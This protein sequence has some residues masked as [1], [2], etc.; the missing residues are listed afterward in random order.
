MAQERLCKGLETKNTPHKLYIVKHQKQKHQIWFWDLKD[1][2][3]QKRKKES[4]RRDKERERRVDSGNFWLIKSCIWIGIFNQE[5]RERKRLTP[6]RVRVDAV[7]KMVELLRR[8]PSGSYWSRHRWNR[9][10]TGC[11]RC[12]WM[13]MMVTCFYHSLIENIFFFRNLPL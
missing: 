12:R 9:R 10:R 4:Q 3:R 1:Y 11:S 8:R 6:R 2:S 5:S 13:L 7:L